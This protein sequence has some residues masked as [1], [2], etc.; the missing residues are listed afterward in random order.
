MKGTVLSAAAPVLLRFLHNLKFTLTVPIHPGHIGYSISTEH[1]RLS[2]QHFSST[3]SL[4]AIL[5][6]VK[7]DWMKTCHTLICP[8]IFI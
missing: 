2:N 7:H 4:C 6:T 5:L 3:L 8:P 1:F